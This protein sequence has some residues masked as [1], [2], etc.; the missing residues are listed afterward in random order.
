MARTD[1]K[2]PPTAPAHLGLSA[3]AKKEWERVVKILEKKNLGTS[4]D[5]VILE[6][7]VTN[8]QMFLDA[9]KT[10]DKYIELEA[11]NE[12]ILNPQ[13][14]GERAE[15]KYIRQTRQQA[16]DAVNKAMARGLMLSQ[17]LYLN[18]SDR[19]KGK[20]PTGAGKSEFDEFLG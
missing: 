12:A 6:F 17:K 11:K 7:Y 13:N 1:E 4:A 20:V 16:E 3:P 9:K 10:R 15:L 8:Y 19:R 18:P 2:L 5:L 14:E